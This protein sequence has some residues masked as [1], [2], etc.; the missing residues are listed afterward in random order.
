[1]SSSSGSILALVGL[2]IL[3]EY[4]TDDEAV[5]QFLETNHG[6]EVVIA[7]QYGTPLSH[8]ATVVAFTS[9]QVVLHFD[10]IGDVSSGIRL[11]VNRTQWNPDGRECRRIE[12]SPSSVWSHAKAKYNEFSERGPYNAVSNNCQMWSNSFGE[13]FHLSSTTVD[14]VIDGAVL[15]GIMVFTVLG[16]VR[17]FLE[18]DT[19]TAP[20]RRT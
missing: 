8:Q 13:L 2:E 7:Y 15:A 17:R 4:S 18:E 3:L 9:S 14:N 5:V 12:T 1:M 10:I 11:R 6:D 20:S 19:R 16:V